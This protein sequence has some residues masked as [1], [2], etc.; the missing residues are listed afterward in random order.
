MVQMLFKPMGYSLR[1][2]FK[3]HIAYGNGAEVIRN[4]TNVG[5]I[6]IFNITFIAQGLSHYA[7]QYPN[8]DNR[9][10]SGVHQAPPY[11]YLSFASWIV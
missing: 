9:K 4:K 3:G 7:P 8:N 10:E 6:Q 11:H 5:F 2:N 1:H